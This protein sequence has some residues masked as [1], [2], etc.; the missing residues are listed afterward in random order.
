[1]KKLTCGLCKQSIK[2]NQKY[3]HL[4]DWLNDKR[5]SELWA[6]YE[7]YMKGFNRN[8][9]EAEKKAME[10]IDRARPMLNNLLN[11]TQTKPPVQEYVL[12]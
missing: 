8:L 3:I 7:C 10:L 6:H 2:K 1:M 4:E 11:Q 5:E 9:T 12:T